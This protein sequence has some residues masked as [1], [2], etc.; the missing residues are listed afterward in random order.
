MSLRAFSLPLDNGLAIPG[1]T[2]NLVEKFKGL[3]SKLSLFTLDLD[4]LKQ[5]QGQQGLSITIII[6]P[7]TKHCNSM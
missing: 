4:S 7:I 6:V 3:L 2:D 5:G 1:L